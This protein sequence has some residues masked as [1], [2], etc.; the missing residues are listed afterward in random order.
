MD[1]N[2]IQ[3]VP[4]DME[5]NEESS[6][7]FK[8]FI[9]RCLHGWGWFFLSAFLCLAAAAYY[10]LS[11]KPLYTRSA[12]VMIKESASRRMA[13]SDIESILSFAGGG[14]M[15]SKVANEVIV[16]QSPAL[17]QEVV[18][19]LNLTTSYYTPLMFR[20]DIIYGEQVPV[21]VDFIDVP[22]NAAI[23]FVV[24]NVEGVLKITDFKYSLNRQKAELEPMECAMFDTLSTEIGR[25]HIKHNDCYSGEW[26]TP[27][28]VN[29]S[30]L[31]AT[32][33]SFCAR[34]S[35]GS[36]DERNGAD[37][38]SI[39]FTDFSVQR[40]DDVLNM[41]VNVYNENWVEDKN[42][43]AASASEFIEDRLVA[44]EKDLGDVDDD[45]S[46][47]KSQNLLPDVSAVS[48]LY[49]TQTKETSKM[50]QELGNQLKVFKYIKNYLKNNPGIESLIPGL[51]NLGNSAVTSQIADYNKMLLNR[52]NIRSNSSKDNPLVQDI[53]ASLKSTRAAIEAA[54]DNQIATL[55]AQIADLRS[56]VRSNNSRIA[57]NP[58]QAKYLLSVGRQ[59]KVKEALYLYLL[60]KREE[61][62]LSKAF[63]SY[64]T[65]MITPPM[66]IARPSS[67]KKMQIMLIALFMGL[68]IPFAIFY[69]LEASDT[70]I[71]SREDL[72][73]LQMPFLG[74]IPFYVHKGF[75]RAPKIESSI[76]VR[77]GF[78]DV[79]NE[80]FRVVRTNLE[81][82]ERGHNCPVITTT[83]FNQG[84]GK[85]FLTMNMAAVLAIKG[86]R[87][88]AIDGDLRRASLSVYAGS[89]KLGI[90]NFLSGEIRD[91]NEVI[92]H[93]KGYDTLD[94]LPV[95]TIPPNPS[96]LMGQP[97]LVSMIDGLKKKYDY[98]FIDCPPVDIVADTRIISE[99]ADR[100]AF[101][102]RAGLLD[103]KD[104]PNLQKAFEEKRFNN[105]C[106]IFNGVEHNSSYF[107]HYSNNKGH[108]RY[109]GYGNGDKEGYGLDVKKKA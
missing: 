7:S 85:T 65:R 49:L 31:A 68:F 44:L 86:Q 82:M 27:V 54:I 9:R 84:S 46:Q 89:P 47:F 26:N 14:T 38:M 41:L 52:N 32:T 74:E 17:M 66:G 30:T 57:Q 39:Q 34:L 107:G 22:V 70:K 109:Y 104:V 20:D 43:M 63:S 106:Y 28:I 61:N 55:S 78:R 12:T 21:E 4:V 5:E 48:E 96:E 93:I 3:L 88:L 19:R 100:T 98:I 45:I 1:T 8:N 95:G 90:S 18:R 80:S 10:I 91:V 16:F 102:V 53:D 42:R 24:E 71:R 99:L 40:A 67:P 50:Q 23:S 37:V 15:S 51:T 35:A 62:E 94:V 6:F 29:L 36:C 87:V 72:K 103:K 83:S 58:T 101:V 75:G 76:L 25:I 59:Q 69:I 11:T 33:A 77:S 79:L 81:F 105:L 92:C 64:N 2:N 73:C 60:Q 108:Y 56:V 97:A 13:T